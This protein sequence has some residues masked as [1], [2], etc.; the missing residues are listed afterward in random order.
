[1]E[2]NLI[3]PISYDILVKNNSLSF[4][5]ITIK[6]DLEKYGK[7]IMKKV[8]KYFKVPYHL[9]FENIKLEKYKLERNLLNFYFKYYDKKKYGNEHEYKYEKYERE[10]ESKIEDESLN[11]NLIF[12]VLNSIKVC[13]EIAGDLYC[14][15]KAFTY[16]YLVFEDYHSYLINNPFNI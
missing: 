5:E 16:N 8:Y 13:S 14:C 2:D 7:R 3:I 11:I 15:K 12:E 1:M 4:E 9:T 10:I 6:K